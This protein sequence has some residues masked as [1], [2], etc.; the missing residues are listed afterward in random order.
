MADIACKEY[1]K[2]ATPSNIVSAF[3]KTGIC[4]LHIDAINKNK[5]FPC[6]AFRDT[7]AFE[8]LKAVKSGKDAVDAY[9][10]DMYTEKQV[11]PVKSC[12]CSSACK[13][14]PSAPKRPKSSGKE[15]TSHTYIEEIEA[16]EQEKE[17]TVNEQTVNKQIVDKH[18]NEKIGIEEVMSSKNI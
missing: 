10:K 17:H 4:P 16:Y 11:Y 18:I 7:N 9:R 2:A 14:K 3:K 12:E 6:E 13:V 1:L 5:L 15:I 8:K